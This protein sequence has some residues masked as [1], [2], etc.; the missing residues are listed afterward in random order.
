MKK[1]LFL[2]ILIILMI[3]FMAFGKKS[4]SGKIRIDC[5]TFKEAYKRK[6]TRQRICLEFGGMPIRTCKK[7]RWKV[8]HNDTLLIKNGYFFKYEKNKLYCFA[9]L[10]EIK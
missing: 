9:Y 1:N 6:T 5:Y 8:T 4:F 2:I 7:F 3:P 10:E